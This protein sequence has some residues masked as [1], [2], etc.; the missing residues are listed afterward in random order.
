MNPRQS[1]EVTAAALRWSTAYESRRAAGTEKRLADDASDQAKGLGVMQRLSATV[2]A[3][4]ASRRVTELKRQERAAMR[5]LAKVCAR[6]RS[7]QDADV[8]DVDKPI[9]STAHTEGRAS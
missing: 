5:A 8:F 9:T 7:L 2:A 1:I 6:Y 4:D 3:A